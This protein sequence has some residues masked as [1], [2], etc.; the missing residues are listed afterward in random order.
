MDTRHFPAASKKLI[1]NGEIVEVHRENVC[2]YVGRVVWCPISFDSKTGKYKHGFQTSVVKLGEGGA[3]LILGDR[4][5]FD[6]EE[7]AKKT[8]D[9]QLAGFALSTL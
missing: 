1:E 5:V 4:V 3:V 9:A 6:T 2:G 7:E 8:L